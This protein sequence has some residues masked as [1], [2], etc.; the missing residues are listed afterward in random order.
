M[1]AVALDLDVTNHAEVDERDHRDLRVLDLRERRP[2][3]QRRLPRRPRNRPAHLG[4]LLPERR[5]PG[6][7]GAPLDGV[8]IGEIE[9]LRKRGTEL[10]A[11]RCRARTATALAA[12][13]RSAARRGDGRATSPRASGG[14]PP[15]GR[16]S[17]RARRPP[18]SGDAFSAPAAI[19]RRPRRA[20]AARS[21]A[22]SR[23]RTA[24][25]RA[26]TTGTRPVR[27]R[28]RARRRRRSVSS[29]E[30]PQ[31]RR[32]RLRRCRSGREELVD[33]PRVADL[34]LRD[35]RERN[36][37]LEHGRDPRPLRVAPAED[38]LVVSDPEQEQLH[39]E[40]LRVHVRGSAS[41]AFRE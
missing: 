15:R 12:R 34:V 11:R 5:P 3:G 13:R 24:S 38:E 32:C 41:F 40:P 21:S 20:R 25:R 33:R 18:R 27:G 7:V 8:R 37:L 22:P 36:V 16:S 10:P 31:E 14:M 28:T 1:H 6:V 19:R 29:T 39:V 35:R 2:D 17:P 30:R 26:G 9:A 4:H 23:A